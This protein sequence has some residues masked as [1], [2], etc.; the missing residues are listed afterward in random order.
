VQRFRTLFVDLGVSALVPLLA[1]WGYELSN[2][3][4]MA[5]QGASVS[6][7]LAGWIPLGVAGVSQNG[8][9]PFTKVFQIAL[10]TGLLVPFWVVFS[11]ARFSAAQIF[12]ISMVGIYV[13]SA[14]WEMLS[15]LTVIPMLAHETLFV[16]GTGA[17]TLA[18]LKKF[19]SPAAFRQQS[20]PLGSRQ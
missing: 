12:L 3:I 11:K 9:S 19:A 1:L 18:L 13:A 8:M 20:Q 14:Y 10:A 16:A 15:L 6:F 4:V 17:I 5:A 7:S 2:L